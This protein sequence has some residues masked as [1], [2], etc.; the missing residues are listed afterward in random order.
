MHKM[1]IN[2]K[3]ILLVNKIAQAGAGQNLDTGQ[4]KL[5]SPDFFSLQNFRQMWRMCAGWL[6]QV[7]D[8]L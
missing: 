8:N 2:S 5:Q 4:K 6:V 3:V 7:D 1:Q